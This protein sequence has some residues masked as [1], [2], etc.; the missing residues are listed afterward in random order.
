[1]P[2]ISNSSQ[3]LDLCEDMKRFQEQVESATAEPQENMTDVEK[4][5]EQSSLNEVDTVGSLM[6][7]FNL[8]DSGS[9]ADSYD[10]EEHIED[11]KRYVDCLMNLAPTLEHPAKDVIHNDRQN[12]FSNANDIPAEARPFFDEIVARYPS[13]DEKFARR[14]AKA[15]WNRRERLRRKI[16]SLRLEQPQIVEDEKQGKEEGTEHLAMSER[17]TFSSWA[18]SNATSRSS[19]TTTSGLKGRAPSVTSFATSFDDEDSN[20]FRRRIPQFP[21]DKQFGDTFTCIVC[22]DTLGDI[23]SPARW[24]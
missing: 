6:E 17:S 21:Q 20:S 16:I 2:E 8:S 18:T 15:N 5:A 3:I 19:M 9:S 23:D 14:L 11:L 22:G 24:K 13:V 12:T 1:V 7:S 10:A 4:R